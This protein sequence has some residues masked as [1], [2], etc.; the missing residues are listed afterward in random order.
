MTMQ[1][2]WYWLQHKIFDF[3]DNSNS[4]CSHDSLVLYCN[5]YMV[6]ELLAG[7]SIIGSSFFQETLESSCNFNFF[8]KESISLDLIWWV[9]IRFLSYF[10]WLTI[11]CTLWAHIQIG[12]WCIKFAKP[13]LKKKPSALIISGFW[14]SYRCTPIEVFGF[15]GNS[16][17]SQNWFWW[18]WTVLV[19]STWRIRPKTFST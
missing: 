4:H 11:L 13:K 19:R 5:N 18:S 3:S 14:L 1:S 15:T 12:R 9:D 10:R 6:S 8:L 17:F 7:K 2:D 16:L